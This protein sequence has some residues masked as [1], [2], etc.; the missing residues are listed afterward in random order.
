MEYNQIT[1]QA[2]WRKNLYTIH[3]LTTSHGRACAQPIPHHPDST[4]YSEQGQF[5]LYNFS[6][7]ISQFTYKNKKKND[8]SLCQPRYKGLLEKDWATIALLVHGWVLFCVEDLLEE[9]K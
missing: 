7:F 9:V 6:W 5:P 8:P 1:L 2:T 4:D 3:N